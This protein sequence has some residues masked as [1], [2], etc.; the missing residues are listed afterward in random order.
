MDSPANDHP[1]DTVDSRRHR[2]PVRL[3]VTTANDFKQCPLKFRLRRIDGIQQPP[4][5]PLVV[6]I[7][8]HRVL[9]VFLGKKPADR[10]FRTI[11]RLLEE[12]LSH[13]RARPEVDQFITD[14][15]EDTVREECLARLRQYWRTENPAALTCRSTTEMPITHDL[16]GGVPVTGFIDRVDDAGGKVRILDYKTGKLPKPR[17]RGEA[18]FQLRFYALVYWRI[19]GTIASQL[20]LL[21]LKPGAAGEITDTPTRQQLEDTERDIERLWAAITRAGATGEFV[22][23]RGPL[24]NW[25]FYKDTHCPEFGHTPPAYPGWPGGQPSTQPQLTATPTDPD[26]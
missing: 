17:Y 16:A 11:P 23:R 2:R 25:C 12:A 14:T 18:L 22:T 26:R 8:V 3:S 5:L 6:G 24:C 4:T 20:K 7:T 15:G 9:E 21:Y 1:T 13:V 19:T 10:D